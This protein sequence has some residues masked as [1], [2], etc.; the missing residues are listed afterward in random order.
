[1]TLSVKQNNKKILIKLLYFLIPAFIFL[2]T[3]FILWSLVGSQPFGHGESVYLTEAR[4][5]IDGAPAD[6]FKIYRPIGMAGFGWIFLHF[7]DSERLLRL[8]GVIFGAIATLFIYLFFKRIFNTPF[9]LVITGVIGTS[10]L[11]LREAPLFQ[12]DI[13]SSG[14]LI[15]TLWLLWIYYESA[16]KSR[17]IYFVGPLAALAFYIRYGVASAFGIIG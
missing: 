5:W 10:T 8:F 4:S 11:F 1:M 12:N 15:G 17:S 7:G 14:L 16:G 6:E 9:A 13:P 3:I 2:G